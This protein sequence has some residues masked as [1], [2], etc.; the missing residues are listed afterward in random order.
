MRYSKPLLLVLAFA[1]TL[2][3]ADP[4]VGTWK[5][6]SEKSKYKTGAPPKEQTVTFSEQGTELHVM[7]KGISS[8]GQPIS[9]HFIVPISGGSGKIVE[10]TYEAVSAKSATPNERETSFSKA[11]AVVYTAHAKRSADGKTMTVVVKGTNTSGQ[12]VEGTN[13]YEKQ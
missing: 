3:A 1:G 4:F 9:T 2:L 11:G 10:S 8:D 7:V 12:T 13:Y 5:L 6:N